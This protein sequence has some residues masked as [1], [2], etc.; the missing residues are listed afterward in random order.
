[1]RKSILAFLAVIMVSV[2]ALA[3]CDLGFP[4]FPGKPDGNKPGQQEPENL[5]YNASSELFIIFD[6]SLDTSLVEKFGNEISKKRDETINFD[7]VDSASH[8]HEIVLGNTDRAISQTALDRMSRIEKNTDDE[9]SFLIYSD[10]SSIAIVWD[11]DD[12]HIARDK[13]FD[14]F[15][16]NCVKDEFIA[17]LGVVKSETTDLLDHYTDIDTAYRAEKWAEFEE[18]YGRE[19]T[20]AY[21][22]LYAIYSDK[23]IIWLANLYDPDICVCVDYNGEKECKHTKYCGTGGFYYSNSARD[24]MGYLPDA[25]STNQA[26]NFL[27]SA[28]LAYNRGYTY[29]NI[30]TEDMKKQIGD[31]I[32]SLEEENGYFYHPQWGIALTDSKSSRRSRDLMWSQNILSTL[33]RTPKY[34]TAGGMKGENASPSSATLTERLGSGMAVA[35]SKVVLI[36]DNN[37]RLENLDNFK[38]YLSTLDITNRS[39]HVG[40]ELTALSSEII[41]RDKELYE[42]DPDGSPTRLMD[43]LISW[44]NENQNP[45]TGH[46]DWKNPGETGYKDYYGTNGLLKISGIYTSAKVKMPYAREAALSAM[47]DITNPAEIQAVVDLY[48]TWYAIENIIGNL[49]GY[50]GEEGN[51]EADAIVAELRSIAA[52]AIIVSRNKIKDFLK[53]DGSASYGREFSSETSQ[54]MPAAVPGSREGDVNGSTIAINGIIGHSLAALEIDKIPMLGERERFLFRKEIANL[55]PISKEDNTVIPDAMDFEDSELGEETDLLTTEHYNG[56]GTALVVN[57]PTGSNMGKLVEIKSYAGTGDS[58]RVPVQNSTSLAS[59]YVF[60]GE[61]Y[62]DS[63]SSD[64]PVQVTLGQCYMFTF[65]IKEGKIQLWESSS[66]NGAVSIDEYLGVTVEKKT[67]FKVRAEYYC[68]DHDTVR[69]KFYCDSDLSDGEDMKLFAVT[70]NYYDAMG[71]KVSNGVGKPSQDFESTNIYVMGSADAVLYMDNVNCYRTKLGYTEAKYPNDQPYTNIDAAAMDRVVYN[72]SDGLI[73]AD[74]INEGDAAQVD[75]EGRLQISGPASASSLKIPMT[76]REKGSKCAYVS[77]K[78]NLEDASAEGRVMTLTGMDDKLKMFGFDAVI[79]TA[80][81]EKYL[82]LK[83]RGE[84]EGKIIENFKVFVEKEVL[85]E[86]E[87]YHQ[88]DVAIVYLDGEFAGASTYLY[89]NAIKYT[90]DSLLVEVE[91]GVRFSLTLDDIIVEKKIAS[92]EEAVSPDEPVKVFGFDKEDSNAVLSGSAQISDGVLVL[93]SSSGAS[94]VTLP[95]NHRANISNYALVQFDINYSKITSYG[96]AHTV[97][98]TD[99][100]GNAVVAFELV[101]ASGGIELYEAGKNGRAATPI[102]TYDNSAPITLKFE[103]FSDNLMIHIYEENKAVAKSSIFAGAELLEE[104]FDKLVISSGAAKT[105]SS[106]DNIR[107]ETLYAIYNAVVISSHGNPEKDLNAGINFESSNS[108]SIPSPIVPKLFNSNFVSVQNMYNSITGEYSNV[109]GFSKD[110]GGNDELSIGTDSIDRAKSCFIF[111]TDM[112]LDYSTNDTVFRLYFGEDGRKNSTY[113]LNVKCINGKVVFE[114]VSNAGDGARI[115]HEYKTDIAVGE[116]F[117]FRVEY[118]KGDKNTTKIKLI[119]NDTVVA[120]SNNYAGSHDTSSSPV[121]SFNNVTL[122]SMGSARGSIFFDNISLNSTNDVCNEEITVK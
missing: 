116:W 79:G 18:T 114:D 45:E 1:M 26:L 93:N 101:T 68:G 11:E 16:K 100:A 81:S 4:A 32:Y 48:N 9:R 87:Y 71:E 90:M 39:Y 121:G 20:N 110:S 31:F 23:C 17:P 52:D 119:V 109:F 75:S 54:G 41:A 51:L 19:L 58:V 64:Y 112:M 99:K 97:K 67:W 122:Y 47:E 70:D 86:I 104:G 102:Y 117:D 83:P 113:Y 82:T 92:F 44:L 89:Q 60:E 77:F 59:T 37:T 22:Q 74:I 63:A 53:E 10:G 57:D 85:V 73:P 80:D 62:L 40:N 76:V 21:K 5:I 50:G 55:S 94:S 8:S 30:I 105:S 35:V 34:T 36:A 107:C 25:E 111:D 38:D 33:G 66:G 61:F 6:P 65:R 28:G 98:L 3:S 46:W 42:E 24:T 14:Y 106:I 56:Q 69:I 29:L 43:Y 95:M 27:N 115:A 91:G 15:Y 49:R 7:A 88:E 118:Y 84:F 13:A 2:F 72:F 78:L 96:T 108:G 103:V 12:D 120:I